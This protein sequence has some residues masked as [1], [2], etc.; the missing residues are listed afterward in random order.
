MDV[1]GGGQGEAY[2]DLDCFALKAYCAGL[3][4]PPE[5]WRHIYGGH[6]DLRN[7][8]LIRQVAESKDT[9][10]TLRFDRRIHR[11]ECLVLFQ[12]LDPKLNEYLWLVVSLD[13][14]DVQHRRLK[15]V[16]AYRRRK[17]PETGQNW[18][19]RIQRLMSEIGKDSNL[20]QGQPK[21]AREDEA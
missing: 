17:R 21:R 3:Y 19:A 10:V 9:G 8:D 6:P 20:G 13:P 12:C 14:E 15:V 16:T 4:V 18:K 1:D 7:T 5:S 2:A 11:Q